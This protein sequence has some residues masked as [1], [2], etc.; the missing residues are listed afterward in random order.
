MQK[1][2]NISFEYTKLNDGF[3]KSRYDTNKDVSIGSVYARFEETGRFDAM[4]FTRKEAGPIHIFYDSD[5]AKWIEAVAY[6]I[7]SN[8]GGFEE[9]QR[10][11]D[12]LV[13]NMRAHQLENG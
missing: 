13:A 8:G 12:E 1:L 6:L 2:K 5:V 3:W 9:E 10:I 7:Q 11:I 4:R